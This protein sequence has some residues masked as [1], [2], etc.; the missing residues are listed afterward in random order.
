M[1]VLGGWAVSY[2]RGTPVHDRLC[3]N[4]GPRAF[5]IAISTL[6]FFIIIIEKVVMIIMMIS[7]D[8]DDLARSATFFFFFFTTLGL[9]LSDTNVYEP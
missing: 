4:A 7:D 9:E 8:N 2:E 6:V 5:L 1:A 3:L